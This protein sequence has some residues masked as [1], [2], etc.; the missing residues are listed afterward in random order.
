MRSTVTYQLLVNLYM[1][2]TELYLRYCDIIWGQFNGTLKNKLSVTA[3][4][5]F[6]GITLSV[7]QKYQDQNFEKPFD[8]GNVS[9]N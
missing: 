4:L 7:G 6:K 8:I 5:L 1:T 2:M 3:F 9:S